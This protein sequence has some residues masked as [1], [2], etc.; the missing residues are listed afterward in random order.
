MRRTALLGCILLALA[1]CGDGTTGSPSSA[2]TSTTAPAEETTT[3][4]ATTLPATTLP[5]TTT[6]APPPPDPCDLLTPEEV[7]SATGLEVAEVLPDPPLYC[8]FDFGPDAGVS[9]FVAVDDGQGRLAGPEAVFAAYMELLDEGEAEE[10]DGLG[11]AAL[12]APDFRGLAVDAGGGRLIALG[13]NG[14]RRSLADPRDALV[15]LAA[16]ALER[17]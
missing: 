15:Q 14:G 7:A 16:T 4:P 6:T 2:A 13:V 8:I 5:A 10:I 1:A 17:L 3:L 12:Y 11:E 9:L